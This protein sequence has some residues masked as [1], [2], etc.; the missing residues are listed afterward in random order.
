MIV[1]MDFQTLILILMF[2]E[3]G[4]CIFKTTCQLKWCRNTTAVTKGNYQYL[5]VSS[6]ERVWQAHVWKQI[7]GVVGLGMKG[8]GEQLIYEKEIFYEKKY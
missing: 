1:R 5:I 7:E 6:S 3:C 8:T 4:W 2:K